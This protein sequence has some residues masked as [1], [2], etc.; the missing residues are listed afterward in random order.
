[1]RRDVMCGLGVVVSLT[2][3][4]WGITVYAEQKEDQL[5]PNRLSSV[6]DSIT[7]AIN[8]EE[9][10][11]FRPI[12]PNHWA[13]WA[14]GYWGF[15]EWLLSRTNV[16]SHNQR[17]SSNFG[18]RGRTNYMEA[19]S[20]ADSFDLW[21]QMRRSVAHQATYVTVLMGHNDVCQEHFTDIPTDAQFEAN[22]RRGLDVL[23]TGLPIG[24]TVYVVGIVDIYKLWQLGN[25][26]TWLGI[27]NC[28]LLWDTSLLG[29]FPCATMLSP[30]ISEVGRRYTQG[31]I[32]SF[33]RILADLIAEYDAADPDHYYW[34]TDVTFKNDFSPSHVSGHDCFH[35]S[36]EGQ[37]ELSWIT[38]EAGPFRVYSK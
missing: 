28:R 11:I 8:A 25:D 30:A 6:G 29:W 38:W 3:F 21:W 36:A 27:F 17:I 23:K 15:W 12:N 9:F 16:N 26:L 34:F 37:K 24:A 14:N 22:V 4:L 1:M 19:Q 10:S 5:A 35:P 32:I 7:E 33:N 20:G 2:V 31:R 13:S 18:S